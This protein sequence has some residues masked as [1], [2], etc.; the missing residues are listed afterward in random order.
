M[1]SATVRNPLK[2]LLLQGTLKFTPTNYAV[3]KA[4]REQ[5][6]A[7]NEENC[8]IR[9]INPIKADTSNF[10][11]EIL[12]HLSSDYIDLTCGNWMV[13]VKDIYFKTNFDFGLLPHQCFNVLCSAVTSDNNEYVPPIQRV[14]KV[15]EDTLITFHELL[16]FDVT[17]KNCQ[18]ALELQPW[19]LNK[20]W[21]YYSSENLTVEWEI[22]VTMLFK[23]C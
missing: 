15:S 9:P 13:A 11:S 3:C 10:S 1:H 17:S 5:L 12:Q 8:Y 4:N 2:T 19:P 20:K 18:V 22:F 14:E 23:K 21:N 16:W 6:I 7:E